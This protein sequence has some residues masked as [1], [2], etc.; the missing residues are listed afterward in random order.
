MI[1]G[2]IALFCTFKEEDVKLV[3]TAICVYLISSG[4][5]EEVHAFT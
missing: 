2:L 4:K 1:I 5:R 3:A